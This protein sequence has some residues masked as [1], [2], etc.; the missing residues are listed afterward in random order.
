VQRMIA[1]G[2]VGPAPH[3]REINSYRRC[4]PFSILPEPNS[5]NGNSHMD[6][7]SSIDADFLKEVLFGG[8]EIC[9]KI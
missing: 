3:M 9:K 2:S 5:P 8:V 4:L 6:H 7:N 1:S